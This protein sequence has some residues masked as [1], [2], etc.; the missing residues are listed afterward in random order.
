MG[1]IWKV[2]MSIVNSWLQSY[3]LLHDVLYGF[4]QGRGTGTV[5]I[6][7][8]LEQQLAGVA[9]KPLFRVFIN[10][11]K[12]YDSIDRGRCMEILRG[13]GLRPRLQQLLHCYWDGQRV[14][15]N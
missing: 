2:C 12:A 3:I 14:V 8:K 15:P 6:E 1:T 10:I 13:Y 5:I 11:S 9:H 7:A 4:R